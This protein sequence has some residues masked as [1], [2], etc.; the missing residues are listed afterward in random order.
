[1]AASTK[2]WSA[3]TVADF[4]GDPAKYCDAC[5]IDM[6]EPGGQKTAGQCKLPYKEP[7]GTVNANALRSIAAI[8]GGARGGVDAPADKK[9]AAARKTAGLMRANNMTPG[10]G[11]MRMAGMG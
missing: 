11:L 5:M 4:A 2:P 6:N 9:R 3:P 8:L 1:M 10:D 7:D